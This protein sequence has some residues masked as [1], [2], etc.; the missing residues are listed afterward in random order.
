M[1]KL[2][3]GIMVLALAACQTVPDKPAFNA[4]QIA[5]MQQEGFKPVGENYEL[6]ISDRVLFEVNQSELLPETAESIVRVARVLVGVGISGATV[7]GHT[8]STGAAE[9]NAALS[10]R[11]AEAVKT[12]LASGGL[13]PAAI[14]AEGLGEADPIDSNDTAEGR[15]QNRRVVI[16]VTP[17][18][19]VPLRD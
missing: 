10:M 16:V 2:M 11:R 19:A 8:D 9:Y 4:R 14:R 3:L 18:D 12:R 15:A 17:A 1:R 5:A 13:N 7:E 6:G